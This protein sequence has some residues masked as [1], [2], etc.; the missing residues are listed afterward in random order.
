[1]TDSREN[2][3]FDFSQKIYILRSIEVKIIENHPNRKI[4]IQQTKINH[5]FIEE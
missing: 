1:M 2:T 3:V 5:K 4:I